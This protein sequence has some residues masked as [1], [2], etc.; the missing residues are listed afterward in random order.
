MMK[1]KFLDTYHGKTEAS[2]IQEKGNAKIK[3]KKPYTYKSG[4]KYKKK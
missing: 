3:V 1:L 4:T 2:P